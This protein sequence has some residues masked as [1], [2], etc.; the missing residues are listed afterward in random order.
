MWNKNILHI[1]FNQSGGSPIPPSGSAHDS[2]YVFRIIQP[3]NP[4]TLY[5]TEFSTVRMSPVI[6]IGVEH[7][8][9]LLFEKNFNCKKKC[10]KM[11]RL[12]RQQGN[13]A[14]R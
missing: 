8:Y 10:L 6:K 12:L 7:L 2:G 3:Q 1:L 11:L 13:S 5:G 9:Y 14:F 4:E